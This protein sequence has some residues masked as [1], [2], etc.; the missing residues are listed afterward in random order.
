MAS[1][2]FEPA[3]VDDAGIQQT[4]GLMRASFPKAGIY[5][6]AYLAWLYRE[7][8]AGEAVGVN[9][10]DRGKMVGHLIGIPE[11]VRLYGKGSTVLLLLNVAT[12]PDHRGKGLF[13]D[14]AR[15][16]AERAKELGHSAIIGVAN[17]NTIRGYETKLGWQNVAGLE[18]RVSLTPERLDTMWALERAQLF[19]DWDQEALAWRMRNPANPLRMIAATSDQIVIEGGTPYPGMKARGTIPRREIQTDESLPSFARP[20]PAV[21]LGLW[22]RGTARHGLAIPIPERA[23][24]SPLRLIYTNLKNAEDRLDPNEVLFSFLDFDAF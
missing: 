8:P 19:R 20:A 3:A 24:P 9:A 6:P 12:H 16:T 11:R 18:A 7:N 14:L 1:Y 22:P 10:F 5:S 21:S 13:L 15:K 17:Q 23:K 2:H 4:L